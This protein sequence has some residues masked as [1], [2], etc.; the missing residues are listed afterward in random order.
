M[1]STITPSIQISAPLLYADESSVVYAAD[2]FL[3]TVT[4]EGVVKSRAALSKVHAQAGAALCVT[5]TFVFVALANGV[6][7]FARRDRLSHVKVRQTVFFLEMNI[8]F[9]IFISEKI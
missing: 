8:F 5:K 1:R 4:S 3:I 2:G 6:V 7:S 9:G